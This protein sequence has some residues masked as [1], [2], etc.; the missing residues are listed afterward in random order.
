MAVRI[1]ESINESKLR[2]FTKTDYY[3]YS[4]AEKITIR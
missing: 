3:T 1:L 4:G 2:E